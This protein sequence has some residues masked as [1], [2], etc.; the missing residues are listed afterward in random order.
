[1][2]KLLS[3][4]LKNV[5]SLAMCILFLSANTTSGWVAHQPEMPDEINKFKR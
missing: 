2:K 3:I 4:I 5:G 1:M